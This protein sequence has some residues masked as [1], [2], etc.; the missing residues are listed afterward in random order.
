[1]MR[2]S[3]QKQAHTSKIKRAHFYKKRN[4]GGIPNRT[5][6]TASIVWQY[7]WIRLDEFRDV[8]LD[9]FRYVQ[10][11]FHAARYAYIPFIFDYLCLDTQLCFRYGW[12]VLVDKPT[13]RRSFFAFVKFVAF[14][15]LLQYVCIPLT[16]CRC[17]FPDLFCYVLIRVGAV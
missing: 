3:M 5:P 10:I 17:V 14:C 2:E 15:I 4:C 16:M 12:I 11:R 13:G 7:V 9:M 1:M 8:C 6:T